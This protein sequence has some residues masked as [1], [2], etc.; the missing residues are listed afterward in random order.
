MTLNIPVG[1]DVASVV[2]LVT[3]NLDLLETPLW[4][5][6]VRGTEVTPEHLMTEP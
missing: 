3:A 6:G 1:V 2:F 5:D 4:K